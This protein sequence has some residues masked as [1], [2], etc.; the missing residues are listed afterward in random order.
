MCGVGNTFER[1]KKKCYYNARTKEDF[2][3]I[4]TPEKW[5]KPKGKSLIPCKAEGKSAECHCSL[6]FKNTVFF[7]RQPWVE[8]E[9]ND[10]AAEGCT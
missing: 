8:E 6:P 10:V 7:L 2:T 4:S 5:C 9:R 3:V 1:D